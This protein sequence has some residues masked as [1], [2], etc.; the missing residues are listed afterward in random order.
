[1]EFSNSTLNCTPEIYWSLAKTNT[2]TTISA[3]T[4]V[5]TDI[6][7]LQPNTSVL[8]LDKGFLE[9]GDFIVCLDV[10]FPSA[11]TSHWV[12]DCMMLRVVVP[13]LIAYITGGEFRTIS[14]GDVVIIDAS[15][16][17]DPV[18]ISTLN[19]TETLEAIWSVTRYVD[20]TTLD[21]F[22]ANA[23]PIP[24]TPTYH[25]IQNGTEYGLRLNT[26]LFS[27]GDTLL[28]MFTLSRGSRRSTVYQVLHL[29]TNAAPMSLR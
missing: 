22:L 18:N 25:K 17:R 14:Y 7:F 16:S 13:E 23:A 15:L 19:E 3:I 10:K 5:Y 24:Q 8:K 21:A 12:S 2:T 28:V 6:S 26:S 9:E 20:N 27:S 11:G 4:T 1:M 29:V